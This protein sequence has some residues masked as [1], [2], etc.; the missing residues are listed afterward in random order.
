[1]PPTPAHLRCD[2]RHRHPSSPGQ[3]QPPGLAHFGRHRNDGVLE[4]VHQG[5]VDHGEAFGPRAGLVEPVDDL[6]RRRSQHF[7]QLHRAVVQ[8]AGRYTQQ[9]PGPQGCQVVLHPVH[10]RPRVDQRRTR[11]QSAH[12]RLGVDLRAQPGG[13]QPAAQLDHQGHRGRGQTPVHARG[14]GRHPVTTGGG[15]EG[16]QRWWRQVL[17][18]LHAPSMRPDSAP[19][20]SFPSAPGRAALLSP[21]ARPI[22]SVA[23]AAG[24]WGPASTGRAGSVAVRRNA[25]RARGLGTS[26]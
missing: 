16:R 19:G 14:V 6:R 22:R 18:E 1:M 21:P 10:R 4:V 13:P 9:R 26:R 24:C 8:L 23:A 17:N 12:H 2:H 7:G 25:W 15:D 11:V 3:N 20:H 5:T